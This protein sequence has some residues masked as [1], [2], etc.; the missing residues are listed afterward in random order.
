M[1]KKCVIVKAAGRQILPE[2]SVDWYDV[3][4]RRLIDD[5]FNTGDT[6]VFDSTLRLVKFDHYDDLN[7]D[8]PVDP[9]G[10]ERLRQADCIL[11]RAS[12]YLHPYMD[13]GH[14]LP[15]LEELQLPVICCGIGAQAATRQKMELGAEQVRLWKMIAERTHSIGVRGAFTAELLA[16][17]GIRNVEVVGCPTLFRARTPAHCLKGTGAYPGSRVAFSIRRETGAGYTQDPAEFLRLQKAIIERLAGIYEL[18]LTAHGEVEEKI[19]YYRDP[20]RMEEAVATLRAAGWLGEGSVLEDLYNR[21]LFFTTAARFMDDFNHAMDATIG[22]RVH[23]VLPALAVGT[24]GIL[25]R[26]DARSAEL[27]E[28]LDVPIVDP[29]EALHTPIGELFSR[30]RFAAFERNFAGHYQRMK[31]FIEANGV[32]TQM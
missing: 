24:P 29:E 28:A 14:F 32:E 12:N 10:V 31:G 27:A 26:Y 13:W 21:R 15:W 1:L 30:E 23:G 17:H 11:L 22:Y 2:R 18:F 20:L 19:L 25:L 16:D 8:A 7:I 4:F 9:A 3:P 6:A 5:Y